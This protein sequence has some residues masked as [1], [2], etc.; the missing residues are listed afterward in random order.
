MRLVLLV[1]ILSSVAFAQLTPAQKLEAQRITDLM[2]A[3]AAKQKQQPVKLTPPDQLFKK[4]TVRLFI[5]SLMVNK[6]ADYEPYL[7]FVTDEKLLQEAVDTV[8]G[9]VALPRDVVVNFRDCGEAQAFFDPKSGNITFCYEL[10]RLFDQLYTKLAKTPEEA[11][12][13]IR[14]AVFF[15]FF[16]EFGHALIHELQLPATGRQEDAVDQFATLLLL[17]QGERGE[18]A[19][20]SGA[21]FFLALSELPGK[22]PVFWDEHSLDAQRFFNISCWLYGASPFRQVNLV[23]QGLL[24]A[25]RAAKC[26][27]EF[28]QVRYAWKGIAEPKLKRPFREPAPR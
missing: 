4:G 10:V 23:A 21:A 9:L 26:G 16:H 20:L 6:P 12:R 3:D 24:P 8:N 19:A 22:K 7:R 2:N 28:A 1:S 5:N 18:Q 11:K 25:A 13:L 15:V 27:D 17:E 14:G